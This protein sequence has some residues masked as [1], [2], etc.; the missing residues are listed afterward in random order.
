MG[1]AL[2]VFAKKPVVTAPATVPTDTVVPFHTFDSSPYLR[3]LILNFTYR[4]DD[5]LDVDKLRTSLERLYEIGDWRKLGARVR[6]NVGHQRKLRFG[7]MVVLI[8]LAGEG[9]RGVS[10]PRKV[11]RAAPGLH[12]YKRTS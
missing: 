7:S 9:P 8:N 6:L 3:T 1:S 2:S 10:Y 5:V 11:R 12:L 4:F